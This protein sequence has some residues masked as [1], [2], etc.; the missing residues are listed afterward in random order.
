VARA[1]RDQRQFVFRVVMQTVVKG[2][3]FQ[4]H[5]LKGCIISVIDLFKNRLHIEACISIKIHSNSMEINNLAFKRMIL[6]MSGNY[7][8][9]LNQVKS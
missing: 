9:C 3:H 6:A 5:N 1:G 7:F 2:F 8:R 4:A